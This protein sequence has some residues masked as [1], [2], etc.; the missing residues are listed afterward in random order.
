MTLHSWILAY[1]S[2]NPPEPCDMYYCAH[3]RGQEWRHIES[4][5]SAIS[6]HSCSQAQSKGVAP[7]LPPNMPATTLEPQL[8]EGVKAGSSPAPLKGRNFPKQSQQGSQ[9]GELPWLGAR[10]IQCS[11]ALS[12][13]PPCG[14]SQQGQSMLQLGWDGCLLSRDAFVWARWHR[15]TLPLGQLPRDGSWLGN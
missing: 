10:P 9:P 15:Q 7:G 13:L 6:C 14:W 4:M 1:I 2:L 11:D 8:E 12:F 5:L 3:F